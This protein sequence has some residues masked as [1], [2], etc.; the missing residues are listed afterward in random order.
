M[1]GGRKGT[2]RL[3][4][5][6]II[7]EEFDAVH[8]L[9]GQLQQIPHTPFWTPDSVSLDII[10]TRA[11]SRSN[12]P[13]TQA[14]MRL[15]EN[16]RPEVV[17]V[18][19]IGASVIRSDGKQ[20][21]FLGDVVVPDYLH[22][23]EY[24]KISHGR[25]LSR[26]GPYDQPSAGLLI[27]DVEAAHRDGA[28]VQKITA[29]PPEEV[30]VEEGRGWPRAVIGGSLVAC[31]KVLSD[32]GDPYQHVIVTGHEDAIAVDMESYGVASALHEARTSVTYNPRLLVIRGVSDYVH[33]GAE[34]KGA[35]MNQETRDRWKKYAAVAAAAFAYEISGRMLTL[36]DE[37]GELRET[38]RRGREGQGE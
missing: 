30:E 6:S 27:S 19:G 12:V 9:F 14:T 11:A 2:S 33:E 37:R 26:Y 22:Y 21:A 10:A 5:L 13:A 15:V 23:A 35:D 16:F 4:V 20:A 17:M 28:W 34:S 18:V 32:P 29:Q 24:G 7:E 3:A 31:E 25:F 8:G 36:E 38:E 1:D